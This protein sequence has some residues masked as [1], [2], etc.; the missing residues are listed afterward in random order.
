MADQRHVAPPRQH[1]RRDLAGEGSRVL[2]EHVLR[3]KP[4]AGSLEH[5]ADCPEVGERWQNGDVDTTRR[6]HGG[7]HGARQ[8][9]TLVDGRVHLPVPGHH[10]P[11]ACGA[12]GCVRQRRATSRSRSAATPGSVLPSR[13][14]MVAPPPVLI[15]PIL[16]ATPAS[17]TAAARSP[18]PITVVALEAATARAT[19]RVPAAKAGIS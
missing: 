3:T 1:C 8:G 16:S 2:P 14:S 4:Y 15:K 12:L 17:W 13:N 11:G 10:G 6:R 5:G 18:P 7:T 9:H 19:S